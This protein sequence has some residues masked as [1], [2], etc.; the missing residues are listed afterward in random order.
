MITSALMLCSSLHH[1]RRLKH[2]LTMICEIDPSLVLFGGE[3]EG[4]CGGCFVNQC[5][6]PF[7]SAMNLCFYV[8]V[9]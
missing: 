4:K 3:N 7:V 8:T 9:C 6:D 2:S 5:K 1:K